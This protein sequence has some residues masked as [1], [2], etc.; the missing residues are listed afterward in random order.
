MNNKEYIQRQLMPVW[1]SIHDTTQEHE[2]GVS[3]YKPQIVISH[4]GKKTNYLSITHDQLKQIEQI[5]SG[6]PITKPRKR[7]TW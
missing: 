7:Y 4:N 1:H 6:E 2:N 5:L 3:I